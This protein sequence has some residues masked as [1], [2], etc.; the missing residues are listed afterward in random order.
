MG[1]DAFVSGDLKLSTAAEVPL[2]RSAAHWNPDSTPLPGRS[3]DGAC[4]QQTDFSNWYADEPNSSLMIHDECFDTSAIDGETYSD[5][6]SGGVDVRPERPPFAS[7]L[8]ETDDTTEDRPLVHPIRESTSACLCQYRIEFMCEACVSR[9]GNADGVVSASPNDSENDHCRLPEQCPIE[10]TDACCGLGTTEAAGSSNDQTQVST[11]QHASGNAERSSSDTQH[12]RRCEVCTSCTM[13]RPSQCVHH[14]QS[15][16]VCPLSTGERSSRDS[17]LSSLRNVPAASGDAPPLRSSVADASAYD[18]RPE[19]RDAA[20]MALLPGYGGTNSAAQEQTRNGFPLDRHL[21]CTAAET[22]VGSGRRRSLAAANAFRSLLQGRQLPSRTTQGCGAAHEPSDLMDTESGCDDSTSNASSPP[23]SSTV[24]GGSMFS[25]DASSFPADD[26]AK[27]SHH[28]PSA[29]SPA[30]SCSSSDSIGALRAAPMRDASAERAQQSA[31]RQREPRGPPDEQAAGALVTC[32]HLSQIDTTQAW[33]APIGE[34]GCALVKSATPL[35]THDLAPVDGACGVDAAHEKPA[36][37]LHLVDSKQTAAYSSGAWDS[38]ASYDVSKDDDNDD[39]AAAAAAAAAAAMRWTLEHHQRMQQTAMSPSAAVLDHTT[40]TELRLALEQDVPVSGRAQVNNADRGDA[41]V[42]RCGLRGVGAWHAVDTT[43]CKATFPSV[44][45]PAFPRTDQPSDSED[46]SG[47]RSLKWCRTTTIADPGDG[48]GLRA[49]SR[50]ASNAP[51]LLVEGD[52]SH[53]TAGSGKVPCSAAVAPGIADC[54][55]PTKSSET[56]PEH[57]RDRKHAQRKG[58]SVWRRTRSAVA[59]SFE[60]AVQSVQ[61]AAKRASGPGACTHPSGARPQAADRCPESVS[62]ASNTAVKQTAQ[63]FTDLSLEQSLYDRLAADLERTIERLKAP[64]VANAVAADRPLAKAPKQHAHHFGLHMFEQLRGHSFA[65]RRR[66]A[67]TRPGPSETAADAGA[68]SACLPAADATDLF[69]AADWDN[70]AVP[71]AAAASQTEA[72]FAVAT[73]AD[74]FAVSFRALDR[75]L[76]REGLAAGAT[77]DAARLPCNWVKNRYADI[78]PFDRTRVRLLEVQ[79]AA[80]GGPP[81]L[82]AT[83]YINASWIRGAIPESRRFAYIA[84]QAPR[85]NHESERDFW[86]MIAEQR[87]P[88]IV[89]LTRTMERGREKCAPYMRT[90]VFGAYQLRIVREYHWR[91][92]G[93]CSAWCLQPPCASVQS[94]ANAAVLAAIRDAETTTPL[95]VRVIELQRVRPL[96][97]KRDAASTQSTVSLPLERIGD[98]WRLVQ[99]QYTAWPD[100]GVP[101]SVV[102]LL[103]LVDLVNDARTL[104]GASQAAMLDRLRGNLD[105]RERLLTVS[106]QERGTAMGPCSQAA[107]AAAGAGAGPV[108]DSAPL[109][110]SASRTRYGPV[111]VHCSAGIGRTGTWIALHLL[112]EKLKH[113]DGPAPGET[114]ADFTAQTVLQLRAQRMGMVQTAAQYRLLHEAC[115]LGLRR[116]SQPLIKLPPDEDLFAEASTR[117]QMTAADRAGAFPAPRLDDSV[118]R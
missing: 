97:Q 92:E 83:D 34:S 117:S 27:R 48:S 9:A 46:A 72:L 29:K 58:Q 54:L 115:L 41:P 59:R 109:V 35:C 61:R 22:L 52:T 108:G 43:A 18:A 3:F 80:A 75:R 104:Y 65:C 25:S 31:R 57:R 4:L 95:I 85:A 38:S 63:G 67:A 1:V 19:D 66:K 70:D 62:V 88:C 23:S 99:L 37:L 10:R 6:T 73:C 76:E 20:C 105:A 21:D 64:V 14:A 69:R 30:G 11:A 74:G 51:T 7:P 77:S 24:A 32:A 12:E 91:V 53:V 103:Q 49:D 5:S 111:V 44:H 79:S 36:P 82:P 39:E 110:R 113:G 47:P 45:E 15:S 2:D 42:S 8:S 101:Q 13:Q 60:H 33:S 106:L 93:A 112:L 17:G 40:S 50:S 100:H 116:D 94:D 26:G 55:A 86:H 87:V 118:S 96:N 28:L 16:V 98:R 68:A 56:L 71:A 89:M 81:W 78:L 107:A 84:T 114:F 102:P 90:G